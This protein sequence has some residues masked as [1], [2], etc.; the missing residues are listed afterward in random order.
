MAWSK[1]KTAVVAGVVLILAAGTT[2]VAI[3][4]YS[5]H[6]PARL[7]L[8][9]ANIAPVDPESTKLVND[10]KMATMSCLMFAGDHANRF[11]ANFAQLNASKYHTRLSDADWVFVATGD[12]DSFANPDTTICFLEKKPRQ[13]PDGAFVKVY[14][15]VNGRVFLVTS[16]DEDFTVVEKQRGFLVHPAK[17]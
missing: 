12:K 9:P 5:R 6:L 13:S 11:P 3:K 7:P 14:A 15:T 8:T 10:A 4:H 1:S 2:T 16:S 17:N